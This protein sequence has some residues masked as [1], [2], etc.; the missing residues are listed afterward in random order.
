MRGPW[1]GLLV[2]SATL[3]PG[4]PAAQAAEP[5]AETAEDRKAAAQ[6]F[7]EGQKAFTAGD[8]R[9][10]AES[11]DLAYQRAPRL[12]PLW[13]A[14][15]A[16]HR[17]GEPVRAANLYARYLKEAPPSAP[18][19]AS[20]LTAMKELEAKLA[21]LEIHAEKFTDV[22]LD[23]V[24]VS[25]MTVYVS[26]GAHVV[27]GKIKDKTAQERLKAEAGASL[28][29]ALVPPRDPPPVVSSAPPPP[30][31]EAPRK[32]LAPMYTFIGAGLTA[33]GAGVT[34][35]SGL[36]T[37]KQKDSFDARPT[38]SN[39]DEG[40]SRQSRTNVLLAVTGGLAVATVVVAVMFTDWQGPKTSTEVGL[41]PGGLLLRG[42]F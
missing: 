31:P 20:A 2:L 4:L 40:H 37:L 38:Q 9:H 15:R 3:C 11:F 24:K 35:W 39:L 13:N 26:P 29:V 17:A 12:P 14:A 19:R 8:Y 16:W 6:H 10:A 33:V 30:P 22:T 27:E 36:D 41:T 18:D 32:P 5:K 25:E 23:G 28:S 42:S 34:I 21:R 1:I 7:A